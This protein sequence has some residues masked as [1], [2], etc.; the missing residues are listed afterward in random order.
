MTSTYPPKKA[1]SSKMAASSL[2]TV[3]HCAVLFSRSLPRHKCSEKEE[4]L[5]ATSQIK[6]VCKI[7][8]IRSDPVGL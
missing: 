2:K 6:E 4:E 1:S 5:P 3:A 8:K 7:N